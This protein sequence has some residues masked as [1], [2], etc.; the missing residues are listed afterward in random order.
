MSAFIVIMNRDQ[1]PVENSVFANMM[2]SLSHRGPDGNHQ[3]V[4]GHV[5]LGHLHHWTTPEEVGETQPLTEGHLTLVCDGR[6]DNRSNLLTHLGL[7]VTTSDASLILAAYRRWGRDAFSR[8][9]G[10]LALAIYNAQ[11]QTVV[12]SRDKI[13]ARLLFTYSSRHL[14]I[15][16][17][18]PQAVRAH[19]SVSDELD[20]ITL[21]RFAAF[22]MAPGEGTFFRDIDE[23][24][25]ATTRE[26]SADRDVTYTWWHPN[27]IEPVRYKRDAEYAE[28]FRDLLTKAVHARLRTVDEPVFMMSGGYDSTSIA[29]VAAGLH[30]RPLT[31]LSWTFDNIPES[32]ERAYINAMNTQFG[33]NAHL[34]PGEN[35]WTMHAPERWMPHFPDSPD[36]NGFRPLVITAY[37]RAKSLGR[38][39]VFNGVWGNEAFLRGW[40]FLSDLLLEGKLSLFGRELCTMI[41]RYGLWQTLASNSVK[42]IVWRSLTAFTGGR[43]DRSTSRFTMP[44]WVTDHTRDLIR[45]SGI[46]INA[47]RLIEYGPLREISGWLTA[48]EIR[49]AQS[50]GIDVRYPFFDSRLVT[51]MLK[52]PTYQLR[53]GR[54][55]KKLIKFSMRGILPEE[56]RRAQSSG[57]LHPLMHR[58]LFE[59]EIGTIKRLLTR[60]D[61]IWSRFVQPNPVLN[62]LDERPQVPSKALWLAITLE[63]WHTNHHKRGEVNI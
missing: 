42:G 11:N 6:L 55:S 12:L 26:V 1:N 17:S 21:A 18:E 49:F 48:H 9:V 20:E 15:A 62:E 5:A 24:T 33:F 34:I 10:P 28:H 41:M 54:T 44:D 22:R 13:G 59:E 39:T 47:P 19:P 38:R 36:H 3:V 31:T 57:R 35:Q 50:Y 25:P 63:Y 43:I 53:D 60:S 51:F 14:F 56:V 23:M 40:H 61:T 30:D 29:A 58:G 16:A 27:D 2:A 32:D 46:E 7:P 4:F 37:D 45:A 8:L 52:L